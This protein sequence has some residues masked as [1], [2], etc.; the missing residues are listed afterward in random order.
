MLSLFFLIAA[1]VGTVA[2]FAA[3]GTEMADAI[4]SERA[5]EFAPALVE[6]LARI[7]LARVPILVTRAH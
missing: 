3:T 1:L 6:L 5:R 7:F 2:R 4:L